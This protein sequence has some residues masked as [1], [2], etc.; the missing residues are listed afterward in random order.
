MA[1]ENAKVQKSQA[2][3]NTA[4]EKLPATRDLNTRQNLQERPRPPKQ[5][6]EHQ[7]GD[8]EQMPMARLVLGWVWMGYGNACAR[9]FYM[10][11]PT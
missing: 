1:S 4:A 5:L 2:N 10:K 6:R 9:E 7:P 3:P 8:P 11:E